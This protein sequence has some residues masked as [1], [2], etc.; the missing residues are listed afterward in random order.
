MFEE[1]S[2]EN[3]LF[4]GSVRQDFCFACCLHNL[5][6]EEN[7]PRLLGEIPMQNLPAAG[8]YVKE[9]L[10][11]QCLSDPEQAETLL[12]ELERMDGNVGA[13]SQAITEVCLVRNSQTSLT[14]SDNPALLRIQ[15]HNIFE[16]PL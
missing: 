14:R 8:R 11:Q 15:G 10:V 12:G 9:D 2:N 1:T 3:D 13:A 6:P 4:S 5:I 16:K 7:I